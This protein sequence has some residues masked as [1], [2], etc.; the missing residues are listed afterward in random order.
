MKK[1][2]ENLKGYKFIF[3]IIGYATLFYLFAYLLFNLA[4][5]FRP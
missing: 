3:E 5:L 1:L 2:K 4:F